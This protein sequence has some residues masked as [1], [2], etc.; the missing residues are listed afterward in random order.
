MSGNIAGNV[1][2]RIRRISDG[3][4]HCFGSRIDDFWNYV[5]IDRGVLLQKSQ[6]PLR[7]TAVGG[8]ATL[9][10]FTPEVISTTPA[11]FNAS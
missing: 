4:Q 10:S 1:G 9:F 5:A 7:V 2:K 3:D 11:P 8:A 6:P